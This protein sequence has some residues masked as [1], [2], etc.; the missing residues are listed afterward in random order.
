MNILD[1]IVATGEL[2]V[3]E[4]DVLC[5][6]T[7]QKKSIKKTDSFQFWDSYKTTSN[8]IT[9]HVATREKETSLKPI[10]S[11]VKNIIGDN[12]I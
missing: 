5:A 6:A 2:N 9:P 10:I 11:G 4:P 3:Q 8:M 7:E 12:S 1:F